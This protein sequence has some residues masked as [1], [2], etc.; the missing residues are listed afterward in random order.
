MLRQIIQEPAIEPVTLSELCKHTECHEGEDDVYL[1]A[2]IVRARKRFEFNTGRLLVEQQWQAM[3]Q[4]F[5][6]ALI[7]KHAPVRE[8]V[9]IT[10]LDASGTRQTLSP[11]TYRLIKTESTSFIALVAGHAW[12]TVQC[13]QPDGVIVTYVAGHAGVTNGS[14]DASKTIGVSTLELAK[15]AVMILAADWFANREDTAP[16]KL[17]GA[18][19]AY[20]AISDELKVDFG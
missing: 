5:S 20:V 14:I 3:H 12:P 6:D 8:I 11:A 13:G 10:Y 19:N 18:P 15:Q 2:L 7:L 17:H 4:R 9:E 16:V 1:S